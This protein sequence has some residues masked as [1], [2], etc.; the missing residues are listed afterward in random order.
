MTFFL[1]NRF[2]TATDLWCRSNP[3]CRLFSV[4]SRHID[5]TN[6]TALLTNQNK[7]ERHDTQTHDHKHRTGWAYVGIWE[8]RLG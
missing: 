8:Q 7:G 6:D 3:P 5:Q 4:R 2:H 1:R